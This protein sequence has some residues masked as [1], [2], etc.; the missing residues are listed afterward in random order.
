MHTAAVI[1]V[2]TRASNGTYADVSGPIVV[3]GLRRMGFEVSIT[4]VIPDER[5]QISEALKQALNEPVDLILTS[6][7]TGISPRDLTPDVT[8]EFIDKE[9]P[10]IAEALRAYARS[11]LPTVDLSR[12][13]AGV[14]DRTLIINLAGSPGAAQDALEV[15]RPLLVHA[16]D[17]IRGGDHD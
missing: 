15:L 17:Q 7:G 12:G 9:L 16:I 5:E 11:K 8:N 10:G 1:T 3:D 13:V 6:G 14:A 2:S 4:A